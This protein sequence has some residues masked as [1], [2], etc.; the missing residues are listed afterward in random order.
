MGN[1]DAVDRPI[2]SDRDAI[3]DGVDG[4]TKIFKARDQSG[5]EFTGC[6]GLTQTRR[7][8]ETHFAAPALD[9]RPGIEVLD[10]TEPDRAVHLQAQTNWSGA[11]AG[12][13][14]FVRFR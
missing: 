1:E 13:F 8:I 3:D 7:V 14:P 2:G 10:A 9:E 11:A 6:Q 12:S 5:I 4:M